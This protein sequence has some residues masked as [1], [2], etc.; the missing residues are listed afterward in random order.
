M[1]NP[2]LTTDALFDPDLK[3]DGL[4]GEVTLPWQPY[5]AD[6][7]LR[8]GAFPLDQG[9]QNFPNT[10][11]IKS[12]QPQKWLFSAQIESD[13]HFGESTVVKAAVGYHQFA[14]VQGRPSAP[15][16][17]YLGVT[18]CSTDGSTPF[19]V[20]KGN[21]L[22]FIRRIVLDP[23]LPT[24]AVQAQPQL[25]GLTMPY[26][27]LDASAVVTFPVGRKLQF[28]LVGDYL[29]NMAFS[30]RYAC[31]YGLAGEPVNNGGATPSGGS[32]NICDPVAAKRT[33]YVA[34]NQGFQLMASLG[35]LA[36]HKRGEWKAYIGYK[37]LES[38]ATLDAF[39]DDDFHLGGTNAKG[40]V[41]GGTLGLAQG[42]TAGARW[43]SA[44]QITGD[45]L[46]IDVLQVDLNVAF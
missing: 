40:F 16:A 19:F 17:L 12:H 11:D 41:I 14:N 22:S 7:K 9:N 18:Q 10:S 38:D 33:P 20:Q 46:A 27:V 15:C 6:L 21:T 26:E 31:Q 8:G 23:S 25:L 34:G 4:A 24:S 45:P 2:F 1:D 5:G 37:Y 39:T 30:R 44:N 36:P 13:M 3:F 35:Y 43:L 32:G 29:R 28:S 42:V